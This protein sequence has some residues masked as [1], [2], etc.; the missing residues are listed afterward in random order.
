MQT[1]Y[2]ILFIFFK[3]PAYES[4]YPL[5][6]SKSNHSSRSYCDSPHR[7]PIRPKEVSGLADYPISTIQKVREASLQLL[8]V[9]CLEC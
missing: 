1:I 5:Y 9:H 8:P 6:I 3:H 4:N 2:F 7:L